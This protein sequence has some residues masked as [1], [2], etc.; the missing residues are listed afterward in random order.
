MTEPLTVLNVPLHILENIVSATGTA[1]SGTTI[2]SNRWVGCIATF[3]APLLPFRLQCLQYNYHLECYFYSFDVWSDWY[4]LLWV[5]SSSGTAVPNGEPVVLQYS[6]SSS[7]PWTT[8]ATVNTVVGLA[9]LAGRLL[10]LLRG[11][12]T[13][14][15]LILLRLLLVIMFGRLLRSSQQTMYYLT[16]TSAY[17]TT[18]GSSY[19]TSGSTEPF[20][21]NTPMFGGTGVQYTLTSWSGSGSGAYS[22]SSS[23]SSVTMNNPITETAT[24]QTQYQVTF[25]SSGLGGDATGSLVSFGVSGGHIPVLLVRLV[26]LAGSSGLIAV[27]RLPMSLPIRLR[28]APVATSMCLTV[29]LAWVLASLFLVLTR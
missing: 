6:T 14:S 26:R 21:V 19:Y 5:G 28:A 1:N 15:R 13:F 24:W 23:S 12:L 20:S 7:G 11:I 4:K 2:S 25:S 22:G 9:L 17:G 29:L 18:S 10:L 16:V 8:A 3:K 27:Q